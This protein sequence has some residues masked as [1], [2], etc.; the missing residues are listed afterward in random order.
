MKRE[1]LIDRGYI[2]DG[3]RNVK[4]ERIRILKHHN[5]RLFK[6][7]YSL[8]NSYEYANLSLFDGDKWNN[9]FD[10]S[11]LGFKAEANYVA[12]ESQVKSRFEEIYKV[13]C[14]YCDVLFPKQKN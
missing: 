4:T 1:V 13:A 6:F 8:G 7:K 3:I 2:G 9:L 10:I 14:N 5:G 11:S 12:N